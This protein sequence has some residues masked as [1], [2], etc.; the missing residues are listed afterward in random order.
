MQ[1]TDRELYDRIVAGAPAGDGEAG[2]HESFVA[3][4]AE[5]ALRAAALLRRRSRREVLTYLGDHFRVALPGT[6]DSDSAEDVRSFSFRPGRRRDVL[7]QGPSCSA[8]WR[9]LA[10]RGS[11]CAPKHRVRTATRVRSC[12]W[13]AACCGTAS[14]CT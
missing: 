10:V 9:A 3:D 8:P 13:G 12:R 4:R 1:V 7:A 2:G 11:A 14:L 5:M 6:L